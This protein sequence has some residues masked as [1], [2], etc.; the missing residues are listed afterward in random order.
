MRYG[1]LDP[2][3]KVLDH[4]QVIHEY[5]VTGSA[6]TSYTISSLDGN[7]NEEYRIISRL[8]AGAASCT[9]YLRPNGDAGTN[10]GYQ[11][12]AGINTTLAADRNTYSGF[13]LVYNTPSTGE[14]SFSTTELYAKSGYIRTAL[15]QGSNDIAT[16]VVTD[17]WLCGASWNN[18]ADNI[19]SLVVACNQTGGIG[20]GSTF[21]I[22]GKVI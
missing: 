4:W 20:I 10:Y 16:T 12:M 5:E 1:K 11:Q 8:V 2:Q 19:T 15:I 6:I 13:P 3:T 9:Y 14:I 21:I 18:T 22:Y 17:I 7:A